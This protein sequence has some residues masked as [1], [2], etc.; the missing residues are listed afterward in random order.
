MQS[1]QLAR[2]GRV[3]VLTRD[4]LLAQTLADW[5][6]TWGLECSA[7]DDTDECRRRLAAGPRDVRAVFVDEAQLGDPD[8]F[9][10]ETRKHGDGTGLVLLRRTPATERADELASRFPA[11][12]DLPTEKP[13]VFNALYAV[14]SELPADDRVI[15]LARHRRAPGPRQARAR[16]LVADDNSTNQEV[17]RLILESA[18]HE[19]RIVSDGEEALDALEEASWDL[20]LI[21]MHMPHRSGIDVIKTY[22]FMTTSGPA[23]PMVLLTADT[24]NEARQ[25]A[26]SAGAVAC[27]NKPVG[28]R[29]LTQLLARVLEGEAQTTPSPEAIT[30][31]PRPSRADPA[32]KTSE[33][34]SEKTLQQ[35]ATMARD[36]AFM[37][38]LIENF[39]T[40]AEKLIQHLES[41]EAAADL[42]GIHYHA[43][44]LH[45]SAGNLGVCAIAEAA[46]ALRHA[47]RSDLQTGTVRYELASLRELLG[48]TRPA[49]L[50]HASGQLRR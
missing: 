36:P 37:S 15:E 49:L 23:T 34:V 6:H 16:I 21:D 32:D 42:E 39:L 4:R 9:I 26:E 24:S 48:R 20:A 27:L 12:L 25:E 14:Q 33:L 22:R 31:E 35:L 46:A 10:S 13:L 30:R 1:E 40:D 18:G 11:E 7:L 17:I 3:F 19:A 29:D 38:D 44:A 8:R 2:G 5:F 41:A 45:G 47:D 28:A 50:V 43:H